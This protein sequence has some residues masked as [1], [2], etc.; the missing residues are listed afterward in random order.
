M[1]KKKCA[2]KK[3]FDLNKKIRSESKK[4][5][6]SELIDH[7]KS[8][9]FCLK[10]ERLD[11]HLAKE[12]GF[13]YGVDRAVDYV[14]ETRSKFPDKRIFL[15]NEIIHNPKVN[16]ELQKM[17]IKFLSGAYGNNISTEE[18]KKED[19]VIMP[20]FGA[21]LEELGKLKKRGCTIV[22]TTCGSVMSVWKRVKHYSQNG[23]TSVI[24]GKY[25]H[26]ETRATSSRALEYKGG[27]YLIVRDK[28]QARV[29]CDYIEGRGNKE[30]FEKE[31]RESISPGFDPDKDLEK[32]GC[33][34]QTTMLSTE[35]S[36]IA[37]M[38]QASLKN[39]YGTKSIDEKFEQFDTIC[40][41]TQDR[42]DAVLELVRK[43]MDLMLVI[44]GYNS[45]NTG[46]L[47][48]ISSEFFPTFHIEN[49]A[50]LV[51]EDKIRY[52]KVGA[53]EIIEAS[54]WLPAGKLRVGITAGASTPNLVIEK[55]IEKLMKIAV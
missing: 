18:L 24:H 28:N 10:S 21:T 27:K 31:F 11:I 47:A 29:I 12:F 15:T 53:G 38:L 9:G 44:G 55:V 48:E 49:A 13:C 8:S 34:N 36:E 51:S 4:S 16:S 40:R 19:V 22:E 3:I 5:Y 20:A 32:I 30:N 7:I 52:K 43:K 42:Q 37:K 1:E 17:G 35:S 23:F 2:P 25:N 41:A 33:A 39:K 54:S 26:E 46:H 6:H 14:Y 45:S 50:C